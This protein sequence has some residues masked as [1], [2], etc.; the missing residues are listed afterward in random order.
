FIERLNASSVAFDRLTGSSGFESLQVQAGAGLDAVQF[1]DLTG[2]GL[3]GIT[4]DLVLGLTQTGETSTT[5]PDNGTITTVPT[6]TPDTV[7]NTA[8]VM[9]TAAAD[10]FTLS[11]V[12]DT[13]DV[14]G[15]L[16]TSEVLL[17]IQNTGLPTLLIA[18]AHRSNGNVLVIN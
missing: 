18:N 11:T 14:D 16:N 5:D 13:N 8:T 7:A 15:D 9:G 6:Y 4:A 10:T 2:S 17:R 12:A 1:G 3:T